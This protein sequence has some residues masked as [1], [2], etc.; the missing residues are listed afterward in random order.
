[1]IFTVLLCILLKYSA[2]LIVGM[3]ETSIDFIGA[4]PLLQNLPQPL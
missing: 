4:R 3:L 2:R 1:M